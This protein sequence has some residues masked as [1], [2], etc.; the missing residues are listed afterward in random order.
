M[1]G[2]CLLLGILSAI[3]VG[4]RLCKKHSLEMDIFWKAVFYVLLFGLLGA[5]LYHVIHRL[6]YF[7]QRPLETVA[8]WQGG[9]GIW[10][11]IFGGLLGLF[12]SMR[13][14]GK[15]LAY[16]DVFAVVAPLAQAVGRWG[17]YFNKELFGYPTN[18]PW[19]IYIPQEFRPNNYLYFDRFHPLFLYES[20]LNI[21][22]FA[23][24]Y[25]AYRRRKMWG[26][27]LS[28]GAISML[29]LAGYSIAR[30]FLEF[31]RPESWKVAN[32]PAASVVSLI[33]FMLTLPLFSITHINSNKHQTNFVI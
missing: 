23:L 19:G 21:I 26:I 29:Y 8:V 6:D 10:G 28:S 7:T 27:N 16:V 9:L 4:E 14:T 1:Y 31:M 33:V 3:L 17:N 25:R 30:F 24:L 20:L 2:F 11:G 12:V 18:L 13:K 32:F 5:R 15:L 22:L